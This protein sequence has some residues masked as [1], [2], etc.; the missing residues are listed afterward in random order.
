MNHI[1]YLLLF[2]ALLLC[3]PMLRA[4][5]TFTMSLDISGNCG[6]L[7]SGLHK[8]AAQSLFNHYAN[9][10]NLG[11]P[12]R[13]ECE[14]ARQIIS[15]EINYTADGCRIRVICGPCTG[16]GGGISGQANVGG[17]SQG[18]SFMSTNPS[19]E[20]RDW[21]R[22]TEKLESA[23]SGKKEQQKKEDEQIIIF[24]QGPQEPPQSAMVPTKRP[25]DLADD[26]DGFYVG[27]VFI[28]KDAKVRIE[29]YSSPDLK[30]INPDELFNKSSIFGK[31]GLSDL[32]ISREDL[33]AVLTEGMTEADI[34]ALLLKQF[35][36][37][38]GIDVN[39]IARKSPEQR[40]AEEQQQ[41]DDY[42]R[43]V[44]SINAE[45]QKYITQMKELADRDENKLV[46]DMMIV[47]NDCYH[48]SGHDYIGKSDF[49]KVTLN[50]IPADNP[51]REA[52][53]VLEKWN[54]TH[55]ETGFGA[56]AYYNP[57]TNQYAFAFEGTEDIGKDTPQG[58]LDRAADIDN[59][60]GIVSPQHLAAKEIGEALAK[61]TGLDIIITGH[62]L[63]GGLAS[64]AGTAS[65]KKTITLNA[66]GVPDVVL[67]QLGILDKKGQSDISAYVSRT[68]VLNQVVQQTSVSNS[69]KVASAAKT[70]AVP[71]ASATNPI[72]GIAV[73]IG[74]EKIKNSEVI[75]E[76]NERIEKNFEILNSKG[77]STPSDIGANGN[78]TYIGLSYKGNA[79][80]LANN[81]AYNS[82]GTI[83]TTGT[84]K[85]TNQKAE[86]ENTFAG[87][88]ESSTAIN[89]FLNDKKYSSSQKMW[90]TTN[91]E[92]QA[93]ENAVNT[94][95]LYKK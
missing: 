61:C 78:V 90:E 44:N 81:A 92:T 56:V 91:K 57:I 19:N 46:I 17:P 23:L 5:Y 39:A 77:L 1:R 84:Y 73:A 83:S 76:C 93:F 74:L 67:E 58:R 36:E 62:S 47:S 41:L 7:E 80:S 8:S 82:M 37:K 68:D 87:W 15:S 27:G 95:N 12:D 48:D 69:L 89:W 28:R 59:A 42:N 75:K 11:I 88:H 9:S 32:E 38:T 26:E 86:K 70:V 65:G 85:P 34:D 24:V 21:I 72:A 55:D 43:Y 51:L 40:T 54:A 71:A 35:M 2:G 22:D 33:M 14:R 13:A 60:M 52:M 66:A 18:N 49:R 6:G 20:V 3:A 63:G 16:S 10:A 50:D 53:T 79:A 45:T 29:Q 94:G 30:P 31:L 64:V 25:K 4:D